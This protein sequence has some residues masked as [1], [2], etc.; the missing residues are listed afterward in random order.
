LDVLP[1]QARSIVVFSWFLYLAVA[2]ALFYATYKGGE[3]LCRRKAKRFDAR[4]ESWRALEMKRPRKRDGA[5][6]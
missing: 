4:R 2:V 6:G 5:E 1:P 3:W